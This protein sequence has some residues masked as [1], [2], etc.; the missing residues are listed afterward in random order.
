M[1]SLLWQRLGR[2]LAGMQ[3]QSVIHHVLFNR[4]AERKGRGNCCELNVLVSSGN[5]IKV[6]IDG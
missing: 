6:L 4:V 1:F 3:I 5:K 2:V